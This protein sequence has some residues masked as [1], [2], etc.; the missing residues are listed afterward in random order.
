MRSEMV[1]RPRALPQDDRTSSHWRSRRLAAV[2]PGS[3]RSDSRNRKY[4]L[5]NSLA[6][7]DPVNAPF[8]AESLDELSTK[9]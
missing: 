7:I 6:L 8:S 3:V 5:P 9:I 2:Q 4:N 1:E